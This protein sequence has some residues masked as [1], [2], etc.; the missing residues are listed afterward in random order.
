MPPQYPR[1]HSG[2]PIAKPDVV[3]KWITVGLELGD[4]TSSTPAGASHR[5]A[6]RHRRTRWRRAW[7]GLLRRARANLTWR[8]QALHRA[9]AHAARPGSEQLF[10]L[11]TARG[12][13]LLGAFI[14]G[15]AWRPAGRTGADQWIPW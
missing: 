4:V 2:A 6:S 14:D 8:T 1:R 7:R 3:E 10:L 15:G 11:P 5:T 9:G 12:T 13:P